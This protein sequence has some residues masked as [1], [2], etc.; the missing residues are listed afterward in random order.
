MDFDAIQTDITTWVGNYSTL[1]LVWGREPQKFYQQGYILAY[2]DAITPLGHDERIYSYDYI[3]DELE[4]TMAGNRRMVLRLSFRTF[5]QGLGGSARRFAEDFRILIQ[6][7]SSI[8]ELTAAN[9]SFISAGELVETGYEW[10]GRLIS[11]VDMEIT[12]GVRA[13]VNNQQY[14]KSYIRHVTIGE[15][16][17]VVTEQGVLVTTED[18]QPVVTEDVNT[19]TV[20]GDD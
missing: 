19:F 6:S 9:L 20:S 15:Q 1:P 10:S 11:Q 18:G 7:S 14:S 3:T 8:E 13:N 12:L 16:D 5:D 4:E 2:A 17:Y